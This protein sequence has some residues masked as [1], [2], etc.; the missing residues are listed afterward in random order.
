MV[1]GMCLVAEQYPEEGPRSRI[2]GVVLGSIALGVLL[3]YPFGSLVYDFVGKS[4]PFIVIALFVAMNGSKSTH[5]FQLFS[6]LMTTH[7]R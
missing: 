5:V 7:F 4:A 6:H 3:G 2:M 1:A